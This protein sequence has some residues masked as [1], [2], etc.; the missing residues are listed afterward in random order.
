MVR[1]ARSPSQQVEVQ[2]LG[3][4]QPRDVVL[5]FTLSLRV[6]AGNDITN[7]PPVHFSACERHYSSYENT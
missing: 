3:A 4:G 1:F 7:W 6:C 5:F 2:P